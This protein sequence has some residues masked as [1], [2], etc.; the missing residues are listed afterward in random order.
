MIREESKFTRE[1][2]IDIFKKE[3]FHCERKFKIF[4]ITMD[5]A[6]TETAIGVVTS[7]V[8]V[9]WKAD[10]VIKVGRSLVN[11]RKRAL[12]HIRDNTGKTM[13]KLKEDKDAHLLLFN[14]PDKNDI[15]WVAALEVFFEERLAPQI[16]SKRRG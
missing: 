12:E 4:D 16:P 5:N 1:E 14:V 15:H 7:G 11:T 9:F 8:Y 6:K 3:F 13:E 2:I 10:Q